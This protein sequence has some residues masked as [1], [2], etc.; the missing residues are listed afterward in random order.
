MRK[1]FRV[2]SL[3]ANRMHLIASLRVLNMRRE[4][5]EQKLREVNEELRLLGEP[6]EDTRA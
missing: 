2:Q 6:A 4:Q 1:G 5:M 3:R